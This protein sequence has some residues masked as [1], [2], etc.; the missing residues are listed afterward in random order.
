MDAVRMPSLF[1]ALQNTFGESRYEELTS[2]SPT[3]KDIAI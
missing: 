2:E 3:T 1:N